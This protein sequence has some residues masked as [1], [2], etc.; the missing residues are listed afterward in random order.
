MHIYDHRDLRR[1]ELLREYGR[2]FSTR[3]REAC[4]MLEQGNTPR[5]IKHIHGIIVS[6]A[7]IMIQA[8]LNGYH[9]PSEK[10]S[11]LDF[12]AFHPI[13]NHSTLEEISRYGE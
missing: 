6:D 8:D 9:G 1:N 10:T 7:A 12:R 11:H 13:A 4:G 3:V 2:A 5:D